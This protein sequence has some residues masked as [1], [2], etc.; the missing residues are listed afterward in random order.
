MFVL[1]GHLGY[2]LTLDI[3]HKYFGQKPAML[4]GTIDF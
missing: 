3:M 2:D 1:F 4:I